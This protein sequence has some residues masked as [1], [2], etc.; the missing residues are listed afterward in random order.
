MALALRNYIIEQ[1]DAVAAYLQAS[2]PHEIYVCGPQITGKKA[3]KLEK[4][5]Y[6]L[7]QSAHEW[8]REMTGIMAN[9]GLIQTNSDPGCYTNEGV[10]LATYTDDWL[11]VAEN[12][13]KVTD[14]TTL[15]EKAIKLEKQG[16]PWK[17][18]GTKLKW[19]SDKVFMS[20]E[21]AVEALWKKY[22]SEGAAT[23]PISARFTGQKQ[24]QKLRSVVRRNTSRL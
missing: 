2:L 21:D 16:L 14:C 1:F 12:Q 5:L 22:P 7:K 24:A 3:G 15:A 23:P 4:A 20:Q 6:G 18:L 9:A 13:K 19:G 10:M 17:F 8:N 11:L